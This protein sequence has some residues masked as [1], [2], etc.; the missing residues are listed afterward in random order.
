MQP[1]LLLQ[2]LRRQFADY[3]LS[4]YAWQPGES[5]YQTLEQICLRPG[6]VF[7]EPVLQCS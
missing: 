5:D 7:Q 3:V 1:L 4:K 6:E 2:A